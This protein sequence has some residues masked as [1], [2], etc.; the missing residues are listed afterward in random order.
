VKRLVF[1]TLGALALVSAAVL[2]TVHADPAAAPLTL[3]QVIEMAKKNNHSLVVDRAKVL[4]AQTAVDQAWT[5]L[6]PTVAVQGKYTR[7]NVGVA[8]PNILASVGGTGGTPAASTG[9]AGMG[10]AASAPVLHIQ[11]ENQLDLGATVT[12]PLIAPAAY[13]A[14][15]AVKANYRAAEAGYD[16]SEAG[17]LVSVARAYLAAAVSD[18][19]LAARLSSIELAQATLQNAQTRQSAGTVTKVD[20]DR[21]QLAL[22]RAEQ[23]AR[24]AHFGQEQAY[25]A[26]GTLIGADGPFRIQPE[27]PTAGLPNADDVEMALHLRPEFRALDLTAQSYDAQKNARAWQWSPTLSAFGNARLFNYDNFVGQEHSWAFG[28]QLDW[29][30]FDGGTRDAERHLAA[31]QAVE[32]RAQ[33][34]VLRESIRDDLANGR[35]QL[36]TKKRGLEAAQ[37]SVELAQETLELDRVQYEAGTGTQLD[38]LQAQ[39]AVVEAHLGLAQAHFDVAAADLAFRYAAGTF[40]PR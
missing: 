36:D 21:A 3:D 34:A 38:L 5:V 10:G 7:N 24:E 15:D 11:R 18:E 32:A 39:D 19:V 31:A 28:A 40:P 29:L 33:A 14:L 30:I 17:V 35:S 37:R 9:A 2:A 22:V 6:F 23:F 25:R 27:I 8:F 20:V 13:P 12:Q 4:E 1:A 26:L 16:V